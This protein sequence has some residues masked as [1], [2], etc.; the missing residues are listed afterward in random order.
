MS[1]H[2]ALKQY[3]TDT[4]NAAELAL[5]IME[6]SEPEPPEPTLPD[7]I[8]EAM[9]LEH[10]DG[11]DSRGIIKVRN[12]GGEMTAPAIIDAAM[13]IETNDDFNTI[14]SDDK[15]LQLHAGEAVTLITNSGEGSGND[16]LFHG[17][18]PGTTYTLAGL[19]NGGPDG[20]GRFDESDRT[21]NAAFATVTILGTPPTQPPPTPGPTKRQKLLGWGGV[22]D[23]N[24]IR[25][26]QPLMSKL[27]YALQGWVYVMTD[28]PDPVPQWMITQM[29]GM[30][31]ALGGVY[32]GLY[33]AK[34][35]FDP[36]YARKSARALAVAGKAAGAIG[37]ASDLEPYLPLVHEMWS[38]GDLTS[39]QAKNIGVIIGTELAP[40]GEHIMYTSS[41]ASFATSYNDKIAVEN[42][43]V[44]PYVNTVAEYFYDGLEA[45]GLKFTYQDSSFHWGPQGRGDTWITGTKDSTNRTE[46]RWPNQNAGFMIWPDNNE[47]FGPGGHF[48]PDEMAY[49]ADH[50]TRNGTG[51]S[52]MYH[53]SLAEGGPYW[54]QTLSKIGDA[55]AV[56]A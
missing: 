25:Q 42:G 54:D 41:D 53:H 14:W 20:N 29:K 33:V 52:T 18:V 23:T 39:A 45:S 46:H 24:T 10:L 2:D 30:S 8:I 51:S 47:R 3:L 7:V 50:I 22:N 13:N 49:A 17:L 56:P 19:C 55:L 48:S 26:N 40:L 1:D 15:T 9:A 32:P 36:E 37:S 4:K 12:I 35:M 28:V 44:D 5:S 11:S 31:D 34:L 38:N 21:N 27:K 6:P 16:G 43:A